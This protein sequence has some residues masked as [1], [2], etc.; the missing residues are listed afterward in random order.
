MSGRVTRSKGAL[1]GSSKENDIKTN[2]VVTAKRRPRQKSE[3]DT[4]DASTTAIE[5]ANEKGTPPKTGRF[6][7]NPKS[8]YSPTTLMNRMTIQ[9]ADDN[10]EEIE[11]EVKP[12]LAP[13][14]KIENARKLLHNTETEELYGREK[15]LD[16]LSTLLET[17]LNAAKSASLYVS[18]QPGI[19]YT[20]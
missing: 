15:E 9:N 1:N 7:R 5:K 6:A 10:E 4:N 13:R 18:G 2:V 19:V 8:T 17:S 11:N 16:E 20:R 12:I 14:K 3:A